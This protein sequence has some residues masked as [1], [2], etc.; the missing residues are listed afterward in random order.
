MEHFQ[1]SGNTAQKKLIEVE[2]DCEKV[3]DGGLLW[4]DIYGFVTIS[5]SLENIYMSYKKVC[6]KGA[7][8]PLS[9]M[10]CPQIDATR[11]SARAAP[12][13]HF[14]Q[15]LY[16]QNVDFLSGGHRSPPPGR[17]LCTKI[18][19]ACRG[20]PCVTFCGVDAVKK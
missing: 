8:H 17:A 2:G 5:K 4:L 11:G 16:S 3:E 1:S 9:T 20:L 7:H 13:F 15:Y 18:R 10:K 6:N 12:C 14:F 19:G